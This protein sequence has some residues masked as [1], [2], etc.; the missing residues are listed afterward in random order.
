MASDM[1]ESSYYDKGFYNS[2]EE[3]SYRSAK[4][5]VPILFKYFNPSSVVD[6]GCGTGLWLK[7]WL[8]DFKLTDILGLEGPYVSKEMLHIPADFVKFIDLKNPFISEKKYDLVTSFEVAEHLPLENADEFINTITSL[9][10][11]IA[12][13]AAIPGQGGTYHIN[14]QYP[15]YWCKKFVKKGFIPVDCIRTEI[16]TDEKVE[17]WYRQ[18]ILIYIHESRLNDWPGLKPFADNTKPDFLLRIHPELFEIKE[19]HI[20]KTMSVIGYIRWKLYP[21]KLKLKKLFQI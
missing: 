11:T 7:V 18:N 20:K 1:I 13:S 12:F 10:D 6:I 17:W 19:K 15:E 3:G 5:I 4:T 8:E 2:H 16:W 9:S 14:E 21:I